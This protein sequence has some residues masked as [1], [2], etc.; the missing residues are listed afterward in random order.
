M[1]YI[2][3]T[4]ACCV[5]SHASCA[6]CAHVPRIVGIMCHAGIVGI[7]RHAGI[8][9]IMCL[10]AREL[11][12]GPVCHFWG[13]GFWSRPPPPALPHMQVDVS[14]SDLCVPGLEELVR[15]T[16]FEDVQRPA[17]LQPPRQTGAAAAAAPTASCR[18]GPRDRPARGVPQAQAPGPLEGGRGRGRGRGSAG[19]AGQVG[20]GRGGRGGE[21]VGEEPA[22]KGVGA[23]GAGSPSHA[24]QP[25]RCSLLA[26]TPPTLAPPMQAS[27]L[28]PAPPT[29]ASG[30]APAPLTQASG[31]APAPPTQASGLA[32]A[33]PTQAS[34]LAPAP[35]TQASGLAPAPPTQ[36]S[37]LAPAPPTQAA[38]LAPA[39][40]TQAPGLAQP[41]SPAQ[42][43]GPDPD[44]AAALAAKPRH[45]RP[46]PPTSSKRAATAGGRRPRAAGPASHEEQR[47][48]PQ[49]PPTHPPTTTTRSGIQAY[50]F[51]AP[52]VRSGPAPLPVEAGACRGP[53][54]WGGSLRAGCLRRWGGG[55]LQFQRQQGPGVI[56]R[57]GLGHPVLCCAVAVLCCEG[58][59][60]ASCAVLYVFPLCF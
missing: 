23:H 55:G 49:P 14:A 36:A 19:R 18:P 34:G 60:R 11:A 4:A 26:D 29:Q 24:V 48:Q 27:G 44:P 50:S 46:A 20:R 21:V 9:G 25:E 40:P 45:A 59:A 1:P 41:G 6:P 17:L 13:L 16:T 37:G 22:G 54:V 43:Q 15:A 57:G 53:E 58:G 35:P 10:Q 33:P 51:E 39:P 5:F 38:G 52:C 42:Q 47:E 28:A 56:G 8:V 30:L 12:V 31:L 32:P 3:C 7:M 2:S